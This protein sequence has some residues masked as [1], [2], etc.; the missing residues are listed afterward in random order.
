MNLPDLH[1]PVDYAQRPCDRVAA[2]KHYSGLLRQHRRERT[3]ERMLSALRNGER[4][5]A[6]VAVVAVMVVAL[7]AGIVL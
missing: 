1:P 7:C 6:V 5:W 4:G 3:V 2:S